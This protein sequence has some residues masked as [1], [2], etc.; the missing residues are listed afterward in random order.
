MLV[1]KRARLCCS[2][3]YSLRLALDIFW[4]AYAAARAVAGCSLFAVQAHER[5]R[6]Q[7]EFVWI[8]G[9]R[10]V[11]NRSCFQA[12]PLVGLLSLGREQD[13]LGRLKDGRI[14]VQQAA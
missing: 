14:A 7:K 10:H 6:Q 4:L 12:L 8:K 9:F 13:D 2:F 5:F 11:R 1:K 3:E